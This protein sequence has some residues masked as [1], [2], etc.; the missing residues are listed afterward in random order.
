LRQRTRSARFWLV[1]LAITATGWWCLPPLEAG[2]LVVAIGD[3]HRGFYSSA[4]IGMVLAMMSPLWGLVGFYLVRGTLQRDFDT[5]VWQLL[6]TTSMRRGAY[7]LAKW[8]SHLA[9]RGGLLAAAL[10][11]GL[12][13]QFVRAEDRQVDLWQ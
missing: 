6:G 2:Y 4:W 8:A 3:H 11:V 12:A 9:L 13:A 1:A 10:V 7:L 5:R